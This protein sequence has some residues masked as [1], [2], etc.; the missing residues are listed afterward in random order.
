MKRHKLLSILDARMSENI[1][2]EPDARG[3]SF[4]RRGPRMADG[5]WPKKESQIYDLRFQKLTSFRLAERARSDQATPKGTPA[6]RAA[7]PG[8][9]PPPPISEALKDQLASLEAF[10][11]R[12]ANAALW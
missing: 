12:A 7:S 10:W 11:K 8:A 4:G 1:T 3:G 2:Q 9:G 5:R 6:W